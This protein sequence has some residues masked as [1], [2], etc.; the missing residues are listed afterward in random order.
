MFPGTTVIGIL[1]RATSSTLCWAI[2]ADS[3]GVR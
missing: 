1:L 3:G 2:V